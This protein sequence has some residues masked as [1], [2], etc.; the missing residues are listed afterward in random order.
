MINRLPKATLAS[1]SAIAVLAF[2]SPAALAE[3]ASKAE[4]KA[5]EKAEKKE[6]KEKK[7]EAKKIC[8]R[9]MPQA[10]SRRSTKVCKTRDEWKAY[11]QDQRNRAG[12]RN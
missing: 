3:P 4:E 9:I 2:A 7:A 12:R 11:N 10:G 6:A 5:S 1:L 8:K